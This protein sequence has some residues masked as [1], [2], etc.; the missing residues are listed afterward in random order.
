VVV[1]FYKYIIII[2]KMLK[3]IRIHGRGGQGV[4]TLGELIALSAYYDGKCVQAFPSFGVE[5]RGAPIESYIRI[6][7]RAI[8]RR[9]QIANPDYLII[10]DET[11]LGI[12]E[13]YRGLDK[14]DIVLVNSC[15]TNDVLRRLFAIYPDISIVGIDATEIGMRY[16]GK[17]IVNTAI[18]G[19][20]SA[21][22]KLI[23][24]KSLKKSLEERF[25]GDVLEKNTAMAAE[26]FNLFSKKKIKA[27]K[28]CP[29]KP[30]KVYDENKVAIIS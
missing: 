22:T 1:Y 26:A 7:N 6:S 24:F 16:I 11:L 27:S 14:G 25:S 17:P 20:F 30:I 9:D 10:L 2:N 8:S 19:A 4:V 29:I 23:D 28:S 15:K 12:P 18:L 3:E 5:R 21:V 13:I